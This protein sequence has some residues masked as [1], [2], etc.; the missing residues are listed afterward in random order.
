MFSQKL[1][2]QRGSYQF[3]GCFKSAYDAARV[4]QKER[5]DIVHAI[6]HA[7]HELAIY[8]WCEIGEVVYDYTLCSTPMPKDEYYR[9]HKVVEEGL[10][11]YPFEDYTKRLL[12]SS[13]YGPF[14]KEFLRTVR[15]KIALQA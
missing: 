5:P 15:D 4:H 8:A 11:R 7:H 1:M 2:P 3:E 13:G 9:V 10:R 6:I 12:K 14:E